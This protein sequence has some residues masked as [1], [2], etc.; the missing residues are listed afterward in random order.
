MPTWHGLTRSRPVPAVERSEWSGL[1]SPLLEFS[2]R[3]G[4]SSSSRRGDLHLDHQAPAALADGV[5]AC[6]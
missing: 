5:R 3:A 2:A 6:V 4:A 1:G